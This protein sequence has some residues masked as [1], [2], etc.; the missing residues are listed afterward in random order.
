MDGFQTLLNANSGAEPTHQFF[1][2]TGASI[3]SA[4]RIAEWYVGT[5]TQPYGKIAAFRSAMAAQGSA[6]NTARGIAFMKLCFVDFSGWGGT[7]VKSGR[8]ATPPRCRR[9]SRA[10]RAP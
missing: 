7:D 2:S 8:S 6:L 9:S 1:F 5:N 4:G 10:T 3:L